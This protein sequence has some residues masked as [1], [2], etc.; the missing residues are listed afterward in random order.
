MQGGCSHDCVE[1]PLGHNARLDLA[2]MT[3]AS[4]T[5]HGLDHMDAKYYHVYIQN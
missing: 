2:E 4:L 3:E 1:Y 5:D